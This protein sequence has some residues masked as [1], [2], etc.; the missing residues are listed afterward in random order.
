M[1]ALGSIP[2][3]VKKK[4][5]KVGIQT[6]TCSGQHFHKWL[7][8]EKSANVHQQTIKQIT[9]RT[10]T[11]PPIKGVRFPCMMTP[12]NPED[13]MLRESARHKRKT[14]Y[15]SMY[16]RFPEEANSHHPSRDA[17]AGGSLRVQGQPLFWIVIMSYHIPLFNLPVYLRSDF[18]GD[19]CSMIVLLVSVYTWRGAV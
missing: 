14:L 15:D 1:K 16:M 7:K 19:R 8:G 17:E 2:S 3:P 13:M 9:V 12:L 18:W 5:V 6:S 4:T 10:T 11:A